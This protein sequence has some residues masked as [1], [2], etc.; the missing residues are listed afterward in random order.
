VVAISGMPGVG[1]TSLGVHVAHLLRADYPDGQLFADM[2]GVGVV[3]ADPGEVLG[4]FLRALGIAPVQVP[5]NLAERAALWRS[6]LAERRVLVV[7]DNVA[8][9]GTVAALLPGRA[10][11]A[12]LVTSRARVGDLPLTFAVDLDVFDQSES[13]QL[14]SAVAGHLRVAADPMA[15]SKVASACGQLPLAIRLAA[16]RLA[17]RPSWTV[18][19]L[20][21]RLTASHGRLGELRGIDRDMRAS[22]DLSYRDLPASHA[23]AFRLLARIGLDDLSVEAVAAV[24]DA[25]DVEASAVAEALVDS[26][27]LASTRPGRYRLHELVASFG[28]ELSRQ[29][30]PP[31]T[32][33]RTMHR[34][35]D[36]FHARAGL[37]SE[38]VRG[39]SRAGFPDPNAARR[40]LAEESHGI[41]NGVLRAARDVSTV[42]PQKLADIA[43]SLRP[44]LRGAGEWD[45][46]HRLAEA[47]ESVA[48]RAGHRPAEL[49]GHM[50][51]GQLALLRT[52]LDS[53]ERHLT[54]ACD[55]SRDLSNRDGDA[56]VLNLL[57]LLAFVQVQPTKAL[58]LHEQARRTFADL[59]QRSGLAACHLNMAKCLATMSRGEEG[60]V[61][62]ANALQ[63]A[64]PGDEGFLAMLW[65][66]QARCLG[67]LG[68]FDESVELQS[69]CLALVR[70]LGLSEGVAYALAERGL[71]RLTADDAD[72]ALADLNEAV[73]Q[74]DSLGDR[75]AADTYRIW[76]GLA[77]R[78]LGDME[79]ARA[80]W[81]AAVGLSRSA[82]WQ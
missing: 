12:V 35:V 4:R 43:A 58:A 40:W 54:R 55:L 38:T 52:E 81:R 31:D 20:A 3:P 63:W 75:N 32:V 64:Q 18:A 21:D 24:I 76:V 33:D 69:R 45:E 6:V 34:L 5:S 28:A 15:A 30:D 61:E 22:L 59:G 29:I 17:A 53:A 78:R 9:A 77:H 39:N 2:H 56:Q 42:D 8:D 62:V 60:L 73:R 70:R 27:L 1:K 68:R 57:G 72:Y 13:V 79:S 14:L 49:V 80:A 48:R 82:T 65:H 41:I 67:A 25:E 50:H 26:R 66:Q 23:S 51:L 16:A 19:T 74:F 47:V 37:A 71:T 44:Y 10:T 11:S 36:R 7:L 46:W